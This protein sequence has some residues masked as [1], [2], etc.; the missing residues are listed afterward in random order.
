MQ[1]SAHIDSLTKGA[2]EVLNHTLEE[3][4]RKCQEQ[5]WIP[6]PRANEILEEL[7]NLFNYPK[8]DRMPNLLIVG[9]TNNGKTAILNRF[10]SLHPDYI[11][12]TSNII[13]IIH[14]SAPI[15]PS[16]NALFE[17]ILDFLRVPYGVNDSVSRKEYQ[18]L[19]ILKDIDTRIIVIDEF[20]DIY[21]GGSREQ[22]KFLSAVKQLGTNLQIPIVA[23]GIPEVQRTLSA[24]SQTANRFETIALT[25]WKL[26]KE[27]ARL[28]VSFEKTL[29]LKEP[30]FLHKREIIV[31]L[32]DLCEGVLGELE[33]VLQKAAIYALKNSKE[34]I[35]IAMLD[36][37]AYH[38]PRDRRRQ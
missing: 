17:K 2:R 14:F 6:Y 36:S 35:D 1:T 16:Q 4:I 30:S 27:F 23:A 10:Y 28:V 24:D 18:I 34:H 38:K 22:K 8:K 26:D 20:N 5:V 32:H 37:I 25:K 33:T 7:E 13:P 21:H 15:S 19:N 9:G 3:R 31:K 12:A 29:P 11:T